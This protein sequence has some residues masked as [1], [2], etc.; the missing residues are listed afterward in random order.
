[1]LRTCAHCGAVDF[2]SAPASRATW[3]VIQQRGWQRVTARRIADAMGL[4]VNTASQRLRQLQKA[5]L[6]VF[7]E[8]GGVP[9]GGRESVW[10]VAEPAG[11]RGV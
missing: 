3:G 4:R 5:G 10:R 8:M 1:M 11:G 6:L 7:D 9:G 2:E